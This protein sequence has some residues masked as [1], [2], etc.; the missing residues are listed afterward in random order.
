MQSLHQAIERLSSV[1]LLQ[2][3]RNEPLAKHARFGFGGPADL[4][5]ETPYEAAYIEALRVVRAGT[6]PWIVIGCGTN[7]IVSDAGYRGI[8]LRYTGSL[9]EVE[10]TRIRVQAGALLQDVVDTSLDHGLAGLESLSGIPGSSG[11]AIYGNAGAYGAS[12]ADVVARVRFFDGA[13]VRE[14]DRAG[15]A[16]RYRDSI[17]KRHRLAGE[18][19]LILSAELHLGRGDGAALRLRAG[20]ILSTRNAK[21]PPEMKCAGSIFKNLILAE[22]PAA[23]Q[24]AVPAAVV[25]GGKV[26]AAWFLDEVGAKGL[27]SGGIRVADYHANTLFNAGQGTAAEFCHLVAELKRRVADRFGIAIEEEVQYIGFER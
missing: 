22:L 2:L 19:W 13:E 20:E 9:V 14:F 15:C 5:A 8:V 21:F 11:A 26:P 7:L 17:F 10:S 3:T 18:A 27:A 25:K 12:I 6:L 4:F 16:F 1:P 24:A 23:A